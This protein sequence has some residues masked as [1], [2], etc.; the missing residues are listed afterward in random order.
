MARRR[1]VRSLLASEALEDDLGV[2]VDAQVLDGLGVGGGGRAV[3]ATGLSQR[4]GAHR[5]GK[6]LHDVWLSGI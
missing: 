3:G 5:S 4:G 2:A 6:S 1:N